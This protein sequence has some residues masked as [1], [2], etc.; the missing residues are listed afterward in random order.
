MNAT[1][2]GSKIDGRGNCIERRKVLVGDDLMLLNLDES[3]GYGVHFRGKV[4]R[5]WQQVV[6]L[7]GRKFSDF[8]Q[9]TIIPSQEA[10]DKFAAFYPETATKIKIA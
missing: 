7:N 5:V 8:T 1:W 10:W 6:C 2:L 9:P 4:T 3:I